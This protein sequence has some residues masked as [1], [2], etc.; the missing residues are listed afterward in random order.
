MNC[1]FINTSEG[2]A[3]NVTKISK[4]FAVTLIDT[5]AETIVGGCKIYPLTAYEQAVI[6]ARKLVGQ[7]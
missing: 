3:A 4:G 6:Y 5:D 2:T 1:T 7:S